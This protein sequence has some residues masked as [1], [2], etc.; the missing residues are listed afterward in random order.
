[1]TKQASSR[2]STASGWVAASLRDI[3][4]CK[5]RRPCYSY[6]I[7]TIFM[8]R[9]IIKGGVCILAYMLSGSHI[10]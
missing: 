9:I 6:H 5:R 4:E 1:M 7:I 2:A 3:G 10:S 8:V